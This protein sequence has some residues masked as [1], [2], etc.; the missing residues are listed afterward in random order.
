MLVPEP[1]KYPLFAEK[2]RE[3]LIRDVIEKTQPHLRCDGSDGRFVGMGRGRSI[4]KPTSVSVL[5]KL[6]GRALE[7]I[8]AR[9]IERVGKLVGLIPLAAAARARV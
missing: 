1:L 7:R 6:S 3:Q 4:V 5:R 2:D 8:Q 9:L